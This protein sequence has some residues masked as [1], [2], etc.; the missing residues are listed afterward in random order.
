MG[1]AIF[2][3]IEHAPA[4]SGLDFDSYSFPGIPQADRERYLERL[5]NENS[6]RERKKQ[7]RLRIKTEKEGEPHAHEYID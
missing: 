2:I 5:Q 6:E 3:Y 7:S 4:M 1:R